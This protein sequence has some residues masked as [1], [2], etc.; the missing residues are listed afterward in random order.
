MNPEVALIG[1]TSVVIVLTAAKLLGGLSRYFPGPLVAVCA[2]IALCLYFDFK[3]PHSYQWYSLNYSVDNRY[4]V[5][6][7]RNFLAGVT[8]PDF[9]KAFTSTSIQFVLLLALIGSLESLLTNKAID[10]LD[11]Q[12]RKSRM[13]RDLFA[14]GFGNLVCGLIGGL[15]MISEVVRSSSNIT[16]GAKTRWANFFH[17]AALLIFVV[18][19][20][21]II[22][23]IP[24]AA[25]A[26]VLC[27]TGYRLASPRNF[28]EIKRIGKDQLFVFI[29]TIV[30]TLLT[31][32][33]LGVFIGMVTDYIVC[34]CLGAPF[35]SMFQTIR[36]GKLDSSGNYVMRLPAACIFGNVIGFKRAIASS[37]TAPITLDFTD[38]IYIDHTF[39]QLIRRYERE[40]L[41]T[42]KGFERLNPLSR[43][44]EAARRDV[45]KSI[46]LQTVCT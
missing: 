11:P 19:L 40:H 23:L 16:Y 21:P 12:R 35:L 31:D 43:H 38:T 9:S 28:R 46:P 7:P 36:P 18:I 3:N 32:L 39:M 24:T 1:V 8:F 26:G 4:L 42:L 2:G 33:L 29:V 14:V 34:A 37:G 13:N 20:A 15:P 27:V 5:S 41:I 25:L 30:A 45:S 17:G 6:V 10:T 22:S 44:R